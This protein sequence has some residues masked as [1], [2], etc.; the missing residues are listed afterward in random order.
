MCG[1]LSLYH[2]FHFIFSSILFCLKMSASLAIHNIPMGSDGNAAC[3]NL[4][5]VYCFMYSVLYSEFQ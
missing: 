3:S 2:G 4:L 5:L 1:G